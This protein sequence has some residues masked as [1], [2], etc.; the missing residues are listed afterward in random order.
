MLTRYHALSEGPPDHARQRLLETLWA[1]W[2]EW[3]LRDLSQAHPD[4][5]SLTT[6]LDLMRWSQ[7]RQCLLPAQDRVLFA[8]ADLSGYSVFEEAHYR[9][10]L[11]AERVLESLGLPHATS[12]ASSSNVSDAGTGRG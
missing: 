4:I 12:M 5:R 11:A 7:A 6:R 2:A 10:V 9:G 8:H 3:I 1:I